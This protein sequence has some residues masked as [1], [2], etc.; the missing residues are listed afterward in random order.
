MGRKS[1]R[2][3]TLDALETAMD[4]ETATQ[5]WYSEE[6]ATFGDRLAAARDVA[7]L[8]QKEL[9]QRVGI[10]VSTLRNWEDDLSE[11]RANRL[12]I[13]SGILGVSLRWLLTAEGEG[14]LAPDEDAPIASDLSAILTEL[15][16]VRAQMKQ[17]TERLALLEKRLRMMGTA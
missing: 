7:Q 11:P 2:Q 4:N 9:A 16:A 10:K 3:Q 17:S 13:L 8:T 15:R 14:L 12:S 6:T 5:N 1:E